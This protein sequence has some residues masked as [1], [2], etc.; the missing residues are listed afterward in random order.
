MIGPSTA[1]VLRNQENIRKE[2]V[3][4]E[5]EEINVKASWRE[6]GGA[7]LLLYRP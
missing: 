7:A 1:H 6:K 3:G 2:M 4:K 5:I